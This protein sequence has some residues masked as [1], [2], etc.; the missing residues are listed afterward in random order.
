[1]TVLVLGTLR[2]PAQNMEAVRPHLRML[3]D[4]TRRLDGCLA[5]DVA[6]DAFEPGLIRFSEAWPDFETLVAHLRAPHIT[7]WRRVCGENAL[8]DRKF[9]AFDA[10]NPRPV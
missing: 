9:T 4:T 5:Y 2:F 8:I 6:E 3:V 10:S 1:M 7:P